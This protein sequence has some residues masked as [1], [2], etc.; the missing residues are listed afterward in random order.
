M[1]KIRELVFILKRGESGM[2]LEG[3]AGNQVIKVIHG[4]HS[5]LRKIIRSGVWKGV[6]IRTYQKGS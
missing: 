3:R 1:E 5:K 2:N 4:R 6:F